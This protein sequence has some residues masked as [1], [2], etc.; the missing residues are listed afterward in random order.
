[1]PRARPFFSRRR[2]RANVLREARRVPGVT[3]ILGPALETLADLVKGVVRQVLSSCIVIDKKVESREVE[4]AIRHPR[5]V[6]TA[7]QLKAE[8]K[9]LAEEMKEEDIDKDSMLDDLFVFYKQRQNKLVNLFPDLCPA[10][11]K[12]QAWQI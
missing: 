6:L 1:M 3:D 10:F 11:L 5:A 7:K 9:K 12:E 4:R 2:M 8:A